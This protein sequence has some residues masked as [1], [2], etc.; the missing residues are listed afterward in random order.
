MSGPVD[1]PAL[2]ASSPPPAPA[3]PSLRVG[4]AW[5]TVANLATAVSRLVCSVVV[6]RLL[7]VAGTGAVVYALWLASTGVMIVGLGLPQAMQRFL[8]EA[9]GRGDRGTMAGLA[10]WMARRVAALTLVAVLGI[11]AA[12]SWLADH[13]GLGSA[14]PLGA[15]LAIQ[16]LEAL[17]SA[18]LSGCRRFADQARWSLL[19]ACIQIAG[20]ASGAYVAGASGAVYGYAAGSLPLALIGL[21]AAGIRGGSA[22]LDGELRPRV[23][24]YALVAWIAMLASSFIWS[25]MELFFIA[26]YLGLPEVATYGVALSWATLV[27]Q[28][29]LM[30]LGAL[31]PH[32]AARSGSG[33][34][35]DAFRVYTQATKLL[36]MVLAPMCLWA[37]V[38]TPV[39][40]P[41]VYGK[42][43][44]M[45]V[46]FAMILAAGAVVGVAGVGSALLYGMERSSFIIGS[47]VVGA[48]LATLLAWLVIPTWG[49]MGAALMRVGLQATMITIGFWYIAIRLGGRVPVAALAAI[50]G[51]AAVA[52]L[53][54]HLLLAWDAR[55]L[56]LGIA[57]GVALYWCCLR[58]CR[59]LDGEDV[60]FIRSIVRPLPRAAQRL[61]DIMIPAGRG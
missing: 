21:G 10:R 13:A 12:G 9:D 57:A 23:L 48:C 5:G 55:W 39:L 43:F 56:P 15:L 20:V 35:A 47:S 6:A 28:V 30:S 19:A 58:C 32:F 3:G 7:D 51:G 59:I 36:A 37:A 22:G 40:L 45:A 29:P 33:D 14:A 17:G 2:P 25:R 26:R 16:C 50:I 8:A 54:M 41:V 1:A 34:S 42:S 60:A 53:P 27:G 44:A 52:A 11:A 46:P 24:R 61:V 18:Y 49:L 31:L 38:L 4:M